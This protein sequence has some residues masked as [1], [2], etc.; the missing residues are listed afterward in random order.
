MRVDRIFPTAP[1]HVSA[2]II[3]ENAGFVPD[4]DSTEEIVKLLLQKLIIGRRD[5]EI[6]CSLNPENTCIPD[7]PEP[8]V[9][10]VTKE[11][12]DT[13]LWSMLDELLR[14]SDQRAERPFI[15]VIQS[16][17]YGPGLGYIA[18]ADIKNAI[19]SAESHNK[20]WIAT[21][22]KCHGVV[23]ALKRTLPE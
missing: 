10:P 3:A 22:C 5:A 19:I 6:Y 18:A 12:R 21:A 7:C 8:P 20:L 9:C 15:R 13:P 1:V 14:K 23:T 17:Q 2:G 4:P 11:R 16:R